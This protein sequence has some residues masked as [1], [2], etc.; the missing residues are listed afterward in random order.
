MNRLIERLCDV[1]YGK[2]FYD[3]QFR[4][5]V[6]EVFRVVPDRLTTAQFARA[7]RKQFTPEVRKRLQVR[8]RQIVKLK[9]GLLDR[10]LGNHLT[11][12]MQDKFTRARKKAPR[13][14]EK[15]QQTFSGGS[16]LD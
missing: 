5:L 9:M 11:P 6:N 3:E 13:L 1:I 15:I 7:I 10:S 16:E 4:D 12:E 8:E 2:M 14:W